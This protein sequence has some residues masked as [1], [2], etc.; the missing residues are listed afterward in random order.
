[1]PQGEKYVV[2]LAQQTSEHHSQSA[3][4]LKLEPANHIPSRPVSD[5]TF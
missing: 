2:K 3:A 4:I 1:M 5:M